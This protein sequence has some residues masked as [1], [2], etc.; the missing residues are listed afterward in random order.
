M[1]CKIG[2]R[3]LVVGRRSFGK[4]LVQRPYKLSDGSEIRI[5]IARYFTPAGRFIQK[6]YDEGVD[7][8]RDDYLNRYNN[9]EL[10]HRDSIKLADSLKF[11]T[12]KLQRTVY[13]GG[14]IMPDYFVPLDTSEISPL[15]RKI[16]RKG[17]INTFTFAYVDANREKLKQ[18][19]PEFDDFHKNFNVEGE[20][21]DEFWKLAAEDEIEF[22]EEEYTT[23]E[24][25]INTL[26]KARIASNLWD[27]SKFYPIYNETENE[28]FMRGL[29]LIESKTFSDLGLDY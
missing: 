29:E 6:P 10:M 16:S 9:G 2:D 8:Y 28:I 26:I 27:S 7:A 23:S 11:K 15:Y 25:L 1:H 4:G 12:M 5:T 17:T 19:Y 13:G 21:M 20:V 3:A 22:N 24:K 14:G 18:Q